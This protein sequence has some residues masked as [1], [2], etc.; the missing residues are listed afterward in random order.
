MIRVWRRWLSAAAGAWRRRGKIDFAREGGARISSAAGITI[1]R[2]TPS[3]NI[4][5]RQGQI[6]REDSDL[7][8]PSLL[9]RSIPE[10]FY[11]LPRENDIERLLELLLVPI[12][13][14]TFIF[15]F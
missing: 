1:V 14:T 2:S 9:E 10:F 7:F 11:I 8:S 3:P 12:K 5:S 13:F 4:M 15:C 6:A